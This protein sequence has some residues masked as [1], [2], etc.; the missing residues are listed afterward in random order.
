[1]TYETTTLGITLYGLCLG[2]AWRWGLRLLARQLS[3]LEGQ[4]VALPSHGTNSYRW[5]PVH[6]LIALLCALHWSNPLTAMAW[7][8]FGSTLLVA[9]WLDWHTTWLPD[10]LTQPL[11]WA[12][13]LASLQAWIPLP[14]DQA[15]TGAMLGYL[16][17]WA[18]AKA[19]EGLTGRIG[20]GGGDF[21]LL[22]AL[23]AWLGPW[24]VPGLLLLAST[25]GALVGLWLKSRQGLRE[26]GYLPFGPFLAAAGWV[27]AWFGHEAWLS[28]LS[29]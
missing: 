14:L 8:C 24:A 3:T 20:M 5:V 7:S 15:V 22:A 28:V 10:G 26:G 13:L 2:L 21:K 12:G 25:S 23:G 16:V 6:G 17:L 1:M 27:M 11:L 9:A 4:E 29:L 18:T 19:F